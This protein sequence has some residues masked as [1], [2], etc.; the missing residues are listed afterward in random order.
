[1]LA[2]DE[3]VRIVEMLEIM[4]YMIYEQQ[5]CVFHDLSKASDGVKHE[6][7]L[8]NLNIRGPLL[9]LLKLISMETM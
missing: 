8:C 4:P 6:I 1:M 9:G 7:I 3:V 2:K 5:I